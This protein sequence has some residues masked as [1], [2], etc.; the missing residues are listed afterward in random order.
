[1]SLKIWECGSYG[2]STSVLLSVNTD[3]GGNGSGLV[4]WVD[5]WVREDRWVGCSGNGDG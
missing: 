2:Q 1:M 5:V 4:V 3:G